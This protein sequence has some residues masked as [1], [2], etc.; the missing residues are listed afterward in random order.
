MHRNSFDPK[1]ITEYE[2]AKD[3]LFIRVSSAEKMKKCCRTY[4]TRWRED[5]AI[6][7]HLAIRIDDDWGGFYDDHE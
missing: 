5:L 7:Y 6:T 1:S 4:L 3:K 2:T